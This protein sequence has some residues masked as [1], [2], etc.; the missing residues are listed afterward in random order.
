MEER[1]S[2]PSDTI[3]HLCGVN[4]NIHMKAINIKAYGTPEVLEVTEQEMPVPAPDEVL[5]KV[6]AI[7]IN[8][9]DLLIRKGIYPMI[10]QF[11]AIMPGEISG[12][13]IQ[14]GSAVSHLQPGQQ[15]TGY[16]P[17]GY[18]AYA[19]VPAAGLTLLP[20]GLEP[21]RGLLSQA[22]TAQH[23]LEQA[24]GYQSV[25]ITAAGGGVGSNAVQLAR[26]RGVKQIIAITG[27]THKHDY[28]RSLGATHTLST[29]D[30]SW[31]QQLAAITG[32]GADLILD[33]TGGDT[34]STLVQALAVNGTLIVYGS[35]STQPANLNP[36]ELIM[37][38]ARVIGSTVY[39][40]PPEQRQ[41]WLAYLI[42]LTEAGQ[43]KGQVNSYPF[44]AVAQAHQDI[45]QRRTTGRTILVFPD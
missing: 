22:L 23:L 29:E 2:E 17:G 27:S 15:V 5:V 45:E 35:T 38:S 37:K 13:V 10:P 19:A 41:Q 33:A 30:P 6:K 9:A 3:V 14:T 26:I 12:E 16:A 31:L 40:I 28:V 18:A 43:L 24:S 36:Q 8:Y 11:P 21:S 32:H 1:D 20:H 42:G 34:T 39:N 44:T 4:K 7:G 25:V